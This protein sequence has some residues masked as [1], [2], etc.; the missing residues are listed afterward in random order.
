M[1]K[2]MQQ[3]FYKLEKMRKIIDKIRKSVIILDKK[4]IT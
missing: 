3:K 2:N 1:H 4:T